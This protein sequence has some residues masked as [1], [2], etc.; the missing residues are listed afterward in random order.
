MF[1]IFKSLGAQERYANTE[2]VLFSF[3]HTDHPCVI[4][5]LYLPQVQKVRDWKM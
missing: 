3:E 5:L 2:Y 1:F 4:A